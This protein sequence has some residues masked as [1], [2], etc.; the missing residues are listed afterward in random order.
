MSTSFGW[1][2][3]GRYI[4]LV[5][6]CRVCRQNCQIPNIMHA[7]AS[8]LTVLRKLKTHLFR[9][10]YRNIITYR[11]LC[12]VILPMVVLAVIYF[13]HLKNCYVM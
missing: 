7:S 10:S 5:D 2:G 9:Q 4:P 8:S 1:E 11:S 3:K 12:V 6:E 13:G